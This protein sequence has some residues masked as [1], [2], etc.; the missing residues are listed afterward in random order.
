MENIILCQRCNMLLN[1]RKIRATGYSAKLVSVKSCFIILFTSLFFIPGFAQTVELVKDINPGGASTITSQIDLNGLLIFGAYEPVHGSELW[2]SDGTDSGTVMI[3]DINPGGANANI[4]NPVYY[5]GK[6]YFSADD[7]ISG[8]EVW[9]TNG[10]SSGTYMLKDIYPSGS[11]SFSNAIVFNNLLFFN[12]D[13]GIHGNEWWTTDGTTNG[14]NLFV[15]S[16]SIG[17]G[18]ENPYIYNNKL[19]FAYNNGINGREPW[20]TDGT[21]AGTKILL[22]INQTNSFNS[23]P[24]YFTEYN[25]LLYFSADDGVSGAE[26]WVTDGTAGGTHLVK[27]IRTGSIGSSARNFIAFNNLLYFEAN[28]GANGVELWAS[29]GTDTG[30]MMIRNINT[31]GSSELIGFV[32]YD[33]HLLFSAIDNTH[34]REPWI[35]DG[36][37]NGTLLL[38]DINASGNS[39]P[40]FFSISAMPMEFNGKLFFVAD[41]GLNGFELWITDGTT[42]GTQL[43]EPAIATGVSPL[44]SVNQFELCGGAMYFDASYDGTGED[45][46]RIEIGTGTSEV[47]A[48]VINVPVYPNP[49][50]N[51]FTIALENKHSEVDV[52]ITDISGKIIYKTNVTGIQKLEINTSDFAEGVYLVRLHAP[53]FVETKK[54]VIAR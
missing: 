22:N 10:D 47:D 48:E 36:S 16:S 32:E 44:G 31:A 42:G 35:S 40:G 14:T 4:M 15:D 26:F 29:N 24:D 27:D 54:V 11:G 20:V 41:E 50:T 52:T 19:Y 17:G 6:I 12:A 53:D 25:G 3:K 38:K 13:D 2:R 28:D 46:Y 7:G 8:R 34:G 37:G 21:P 30:T 45:L 43:I 49:S 51:F 23:L 9:V 5:N 1:T 33:N 18:P 39:M